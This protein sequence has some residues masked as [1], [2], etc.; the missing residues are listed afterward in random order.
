MDY[1][2]HDLAKT[3]NFDLETATNATEVIAAALRE[4]YP[5]ASDALFAAIRGDRARLEV[6]EVEKIA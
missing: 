5:E 6:V 4:D 3:L 2:N 1:V